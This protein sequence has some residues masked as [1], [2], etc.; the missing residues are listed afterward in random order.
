MKLS[1]R[2][3]LLCACLYYA[4]HMSKICVAC[5]VLFY[6]SGLTYWSSSKNFLLT[7]QAD[8]F[9]LPP[10]VNEWLKLTRARSKYCNSNS[11]SLFTYCPA[12]AAVSARADISHVAYV[13]KTLSPFS[14][15]SFCLNSYFRRLAQALR[16]ERAAHFHMRASTPPSCEPLQCKAPYKG[17]LMM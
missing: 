16:P 13:N 8:S 10:W 3:N 14:V 17:M 5:L 9:F 7:L 12:S 1:E 4:F 6:G 15:T 11:S 2:Q